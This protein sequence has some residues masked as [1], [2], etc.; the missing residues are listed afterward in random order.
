MTYD[1]GL[2][3][4]PLCDRASYTYDENP[5]LNWAFL[6][7]LILCVPVAS[8]IWAGIIYSVSRLAR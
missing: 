7:G 5:E 1:S 2:V 4:Q 8:A 3:F 6:K